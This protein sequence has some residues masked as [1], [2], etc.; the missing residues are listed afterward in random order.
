M[1]ELVATCRMCQTQYTLYVDAKD[2]EDY[3]D[4]DKLA[5]DA[6]PYLDAGQ[7][8]LII[9]GICGECFDRI[10]KQ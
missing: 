3:T 5:Q 9:S 2:W 8:E 6:F 1:I 7:R 10:F 4:R